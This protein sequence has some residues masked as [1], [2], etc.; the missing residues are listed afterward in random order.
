MVMA[1]VKDLMRWAETE[2]RNLYYPQHWRTIETRV[3]PTYLNQF[4]LRQR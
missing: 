3:L 2:K 4:S 1:E